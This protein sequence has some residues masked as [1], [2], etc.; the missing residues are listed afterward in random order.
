[1]K[2][3]MQIADLGGGCFWNIE[4]IFRTQAGVVKTE[5]GYEGGHVDHPSYEQV[6]THTTGHAETVQITFDPNTISFQQILQIFF[7]HIN[8]TEL[9]HQ[10][11]DVGDNYRSVIF[12]HDAEQ[13]RLAEDYIKQ[14]QTKYRDPIVTQVVPATTFWGGEDYHQQYLHKRDLGICY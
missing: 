3:D 12:Y 8:P 14:Q 13:K 7:E 2:S 11:P 9:D 1:M 5:V 6:I 10:G 4:E